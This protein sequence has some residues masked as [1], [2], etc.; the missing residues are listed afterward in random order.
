MM[1]CIKCGNQEADGVKFCTSCGAVMT[2]EPAGEPPRQAIEA[3]PSA[4]RPQPEAYREE[5]VST[6]GWVWILFA[7]MIPLLNLLLLLIWACGGCRKASKRNFARAV[8]LWTVIGGILATLVL[9]AGSLLFG[10]QFDALK[11][12]LMQMKNFK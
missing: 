2:M 3:T 6:G 1:Y 4:N 5:P 12:S 10:E 7:L 8:L 11:E 9:L